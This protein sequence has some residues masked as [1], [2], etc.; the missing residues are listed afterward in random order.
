MEK[1]SLRKEDEIKWTKVYE[2]AVG[3]VVAFVVAVAYRFSI[4]TIE[5]LFHF[6]SKFLDPLVIA[7]FFGLPGILSCVLFYIYS[8][9]LM[10]SVVIGI[11]SIL[12]FVIVFILTL[13]RLPGIP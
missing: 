1:N 11:L 2:W 9:N 3:L 8:R 4:G 13:T 6:I 10:R 7:L 5:P 12:I